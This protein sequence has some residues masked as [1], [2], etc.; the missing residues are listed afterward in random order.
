MKRLKFKMIACISLVLMLISIPSFTFSKYTET[1]NGFCWTTRF[2][3]FGINTNSFIIT[4]E[5]Q[6]SDALWG[7]EN[8]DGDYN[9]STLQNEEFGA[10]N[11]TDQKRLIIFEVAINEKTFLYGGTNY[12]F[13]IINKDN[14][15]YSISGRLVKKESSVVSDTDILLNYDGASGWGGG[16][17]SAAINPIT[18]GISTDIIEKGFVV[19]SGKPIMFKL[20]VG[21][22]SG[23]G[24]IVSEFLYV[25]INTIP[26][27]PS[28]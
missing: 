2:S 4:E 14:E 11:R 5:K 23:Y 3:D 24:S 13:S 25:K 1:Y 27:P 26:Y 6:K 21:T 7:Q 20:T 8:K 16:R 15:S 9:F 19:E 17:Y 12:K 28:A 10:I 18:M 22:E